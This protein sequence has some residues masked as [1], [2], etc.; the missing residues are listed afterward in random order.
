MA[1][2]VRN[3]HVS[4]SFHRLVKERR[5]PDGE[6]HVE[7]FSEADFKALG[8]S[9]ENFP[10]VD[11]KDPLT[12]EKLR[13]KTLVKINSVEIVDSRTI[14]GRF[15]SPYSGHAYDNSEKGKIPANSISLRPFFFIIYPVYAGLVFTHFCMGA[16]SDSRRSIL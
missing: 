9:L 4:V 8:R 13:Y 16:L 12:Q 10:S 15:E 7:S 5:L 3:E 2:T 1:R 14:F 11:I 6:V